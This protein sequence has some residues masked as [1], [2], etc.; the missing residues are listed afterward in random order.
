MNSDFSGSRK[1]YSGAHTASWTRD[2]NYITAINASD[3]HKV[4]RIKASD[5]RDSMP[6][7]RPRVSNGSSIAAA[8]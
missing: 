4:I 6:I 8:C 1:V 2:G 3:E 5:G 7:S